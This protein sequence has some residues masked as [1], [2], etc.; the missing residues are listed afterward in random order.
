MKTIFKY[1][2]NTI[3][4]PTSAKVVHFGTDAQNVECIWI[5]HDTLEIPTFPRHYKVFGTGDS[6]PEG[7]TWQATYINDPFVWHLYEILK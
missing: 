4:L 7:S 1:S 6:I 5:E 3:N 2:S